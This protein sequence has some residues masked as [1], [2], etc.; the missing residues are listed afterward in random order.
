M[1]HRAAG[2]RSA[3]L[4]VLVGLR[5]ATVSSPSRLWPEYP[6]CQGRANVDWKQ[7]Y[8][9]ERAGEGAREAIEAWLL[10]EPKLIAA[11]ARRAVVSFP[12]TALRYAGPLQ[13]KVVRALYESRGI[14]RVLALGVLHSGGLDVY[15]TALDE[16]VELERR[17]LAFRAVRG[18]FLPAGDSLETTYGV[19]PRWTP[20]AGAEDVRADRDGL[21]GAEFSLDMFQS[22]VRVAADALGRRPLPVLPVYIG[23]TRDPVSGSFESADRVADW[24][25]FHVDRSTAIVATGDL[26]HYG[27]A[28]GGAWVPG[29]PISIEA[30]RH[31]LEPEVERVFAAAFGDRDWETAYRLSRGRLGNDQREMLAVVSSVLGKGASGALL[32]FELSDYAEILG[33]APPCVVASILAFYERAQ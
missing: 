12:H 23:M 4:L 22:V 30:L 13:A 6:R 27:T 21:L 16:R 28:Y 1:S 20:L 10:P 17:A 24:I 19:V 18:A 9:R 32:S 25:R 2:A 8:E 7:F 3:S 5:T 11:I 26:I 31:A 15:Q 14:E 33:V 29:N